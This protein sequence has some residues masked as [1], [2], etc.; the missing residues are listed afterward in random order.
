MRARRLLVVGLVASTVVLVAQVEGA[1]ATNAGAQHAG[2]S[3][4]RVVSGVTT[5]M[6]NSDPTWAIQKTPKESQ[7]PSV[8]EAVSCASAEACTAVGTYTIDSGLQML[9]AETWNGES[10][11]QK[12]TPTIINYED[13]GADAVFEGV[14]CVSAT[15][16]EAVGWSNFS[17]GDPDQ[18][19]Y[20]LA[21]VWNG[22]T[23]SQQS[24]PNASSPTDGQNDLSSVSCT[25]TGTYCAAVGWTLNGAG[26]QVPATLAEV[27]NG[28]SWAIEP[29]PDLSGTASLSGVSCISTTACTA[30][31]TANGQVLSETWNGTSWTQQTTPYPSGATAS[32]LSGVSCTSATSCSAVGTYTDASGSFALAEEW[33]GTKWKIKTVS[34]PAGATSSSL[35]DVSCGA[36]QACSGVGQ[37]DAGNGDQT[38][39][40]AW[41][42]TSWT[43]ETT[44]SPPGATA[45][46]LSG[47]SCTSAQSTACIAVGDDTNSGGTS[48]V[49]SDAWNGTAWSS[50][51]IPDGGI[52][53]Q[54]L[55][56]VSCTSATDCEATGG[57]SDGASFTEGWNGTKWALQATQIQ[58]E[59]Y[60][61]AL[62]S[63][64]SG[65]SCF[66]A[67]SCTA[68][69]GSLYYTPETYFTGPDPWVEAW[70][71]SAWT[72]Q[73]LALSAIIQMYLN[74]VS[75]YSATGCTAVGVSSASPGT[76]IET[77]NGTAWSTETAAIPSGATTIGLD[78]V[79]CTASTACMLVGSYTASTGTQSTLAELWNGTKWKIKTTPAPTGAT[80]SSLSSVSCTSGT[81]CTAVGSY[82]GSSGT[83]STLAEVWNG[84]TWTIEPTSAPSGAKTSSLSSVSCT[85]STACTAVGSYKALSGTRSTLA[86]V[87]DGTTWTV[88][89]TPNP[90]GATSAVL[91][92][93]SCWARRSGQA[94]TSVGSFTDQNGNAE[95]LAESN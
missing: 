22:T 93:V 12:S 79:S 57:F 53:T 76:L 24:T 10:W 23:W 49:I 42:G 4:P 43:F 9:L 68:A 33:N 20:T 59:F 48:D 18:P 64:L 71:G 8:G 77:W 88:E 2:R 37:F 82:T 1:S 51:K 45:S 69:G 13:Y 73:Y 81:A 58:Y 28:T 19:S 44:P 80:A 54:A 5:G 70:N 34:E 47:I 86:E 15:A 17:E 63:K 11:A 89:V 31:G 87:W 3:T 27:W 6:R 38:L 75:C 21:A 83:A 74:G 40:E 29:T 55:T 56:A 65:I 50:Q 25:G 30:V 32:S 78:A 94:C 62:Q 41:N 35:S 85:S 95:T 52:P 72:S 66:S 36:A 67:S 84:A 14:S 61:I 92:G 39:A 16:C 26:T 90:S 46:S 60:Y 7:E 91:S